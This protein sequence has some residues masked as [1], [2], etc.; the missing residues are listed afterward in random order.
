MRVGRTLALL[1]AW[2]S[3]VA[4][5]SV[6]GATD[7][8]TSAGAGGAAASQ[9]QGRDRP[10]FSHAQHVGEVW[11]V[12]Q[13]E[14]VWRDCRGCHRFDAAN[15]VSAPQQQ[16]DACH[17]RGNLTPDYAPGWERDLGR[18][19]YRT[20]TREAFR[21]HTHGMLECRECHLPADTR[22]LKDFDVVTGPGQCARCHDQTLLEATKYSQIEN[23]RWFRGALQ[24]Q[25]PA[26]LGVEPFQRPPDPKAYAERLVAVFA[27]ENG[28]INVKP[29]AI[30]GDF[31]H[32]DH[33][34][35]ACRDCHT[36]ITAASAFE[37]G[38]GQIPAGGCGT[39][40]QKDAAGAPAAPAAAARAEPR[41]LWSLGAFVHADHYRFLQDGQQPR[42]GVATEAA[43]A[44]LRAS[45]TGGCDVCHVQD[46]AAA[47]LSRRDFPFEP[48][49]G[50]DA[51]AARGSKHRYLDCVTCH[52]VPGWRTGE[53]KDRPL[54][55]SADDR[56]GD[57][58]S[59]W[60]ACASCHEFA[61]P[62]FVSKRPVAAVRRAGGGTFAFARHTHPDITTA[63][64]DDAG[65]PALQDCKECH[66][67]QVPDL[68]SRIVARPFRHATHVAPN[69]T[70]AACLECHP[71]AA[72]AA[73]S[74]GLAG[75]DFRTFS[76]TGCAKCHL[77]G[78]LTQTPAPRRDEP[79]AARTV[80][81]FP[82]GPH[83]AAGAKCADCHALAG[84]GAGVTT[85][86]EA[87]ACTKCHDHVEGG[88]TAELLFGDE[89][90]SCR[91]CHHDPA[92]P[93]SQPA[94]LTLPALRGS[95]A[96]ANDPRYAAT[97]SVFAGFADPQ[98][99]PLGQ[100]CTDCHRA[101]L[102]PDPRWSGIRIKGEHHLFLAER[103]RSPHAGQTGKQPASCLRCH[104]KPLNGLEDGVDAGTPQER[105]WRRAPSSRDTRRE[106]GNDA[107]GY[108]GTDAAR[109]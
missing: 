102:A 92:T 56:P 77:G 58:R 86:A 104:W 1:V 60:A 42:E 94:V 43:Y 9:G 73:D 93:A 2:A 81:A 16:C 21:H 36:N 49:P 47:G 48:E 12:T 96:A 31:D 105:A 30:G 13:T 75:D 4:F 76:L 34:D 14:E 63:G 33:G 72:T 66:R 91:Q 103:G 6:P 54:H 87:L 15:Q 17:L 69:A 46:A 109:G 22:F 97:Q 44:L 82:H 5:T 41:P 65:R 79:P 100:A 53:T 19:P 50:S 45:K 11:F 64:I 68:A 83:A 61:Q 106:F 3:A 71:R 80:V 78:E 101:D 18:P 8:D 88:S 107:K 23:M 84:D 59:G 39:C 57:G 55:D 67:A 10:R 29:P 70:E 74:G 37:V 51:G 62:D 28:G 95:P 27:G 90:K 20:R 52:D 89:V 26:E 24:P 98:F 108:P 7:A 99:H 32:A 25:V 35:I 38:T 85:S 40:H